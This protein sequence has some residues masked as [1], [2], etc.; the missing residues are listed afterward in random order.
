[1]YMYVNSDSAGNKQNTCLFIYKNDELVGL[2]FDDLRDW[3][4][5]GGPRCANDS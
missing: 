3:S 2:Q 1:M 4:N 5:L